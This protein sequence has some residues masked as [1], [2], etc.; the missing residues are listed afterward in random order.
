MANDAEEPP[1]KKIPAPPPDVAGPAPGDPK[2][3]GEKEAAQLSRGKAERDLKK[4]QEEKDHD[5]GEKFRDHF[6][7]LAV[8][9]MYIMFFV[10]GIF[11]IVW[12]LHM[13]LPDTCT[14]FWTFGL[15]TSLCRWL[16]PDQVA[17]I[18]DILTGGLFAG[19]LADHFR[20]R[21]AR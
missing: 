1:K 11:G 20:R 17:I 12:I 7:R 15:K 10:L 3:S 6:E 8:W 4:E 16:K 2:D 14:N 18:Q 5:R 21:M 19:L 9:A 13:I